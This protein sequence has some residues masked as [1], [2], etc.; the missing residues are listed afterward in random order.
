[1]RGELPPQRK[2]LGSVTLCLFFKR[3]ASPFQLLQE[4]RLGGGRLWLRHLLGQIGLGG[5]FLAIGRGAN[6]D[7]W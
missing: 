3:L 7:G 1:M 4:V 5:A 6:A 2:A